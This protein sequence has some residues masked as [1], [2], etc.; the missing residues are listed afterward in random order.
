MLKDKFK[1]LRIIIIFSLGISI[2]NCILY[3]DLIDLTAWLVS[4]A[5]QII[6]LLLIRELKQKT[7]KD[8][9]DSIE[10]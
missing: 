5:Y 1:F 3:I 10:M 2:L 4:A 7:K 9:N 6:I 8:D